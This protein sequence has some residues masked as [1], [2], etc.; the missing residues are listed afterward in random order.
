M[1]R[2][3]VHAHFIPDG[4]RQ[5]LEAAGHAS[6]DG[7]LVIPVWDPAEHV[8]VMDRLE[9]D[10]AL[11]SISSPGVHFGDDA[12]ARALAREVNT[13]GREAALRHP[14]RFGLLAV[15][16]LPDVAGAL[17]EIAYAYDHL[18]AD[19]V[20]LLTNVGGMYLGDPALQPIFEE[21][22]RRHARVFLHPTSPPCWQQTSFGRPRPM[23]EFLF[24]TTRTVVDLVLN[25]TVARHSHIEFII[26]HAGAS[27]PAIADR[28]ARFSLF[29]PD[30]DASADVLVDL[31][32]L[33]YDLAGTP[34]PRQLDALLSIAT[35]DHLHYGS[36]Y[37]FTPELAVRRLAG[38]LDAVR[39]PSGLVDQL[40]EN[41]RALFPRLGDTESPP[42]HSGVG[43]P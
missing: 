12:A 27:L 9:I 40:T 11:L 14:G 5:A 15:L 24:D 17:R 16:P 36:D 30:V 33:H 35:P 23:L 18:R 26:P 1:S 41:T 39:E 13:I 32:R 25:G 37:P 22:D 38:A 20:A 19:G 28:V 31:R 29:L 42:Q 6:P 10:T 3:D 7:F 43:P 34:L 4:Y 8:A 2:L 21:L